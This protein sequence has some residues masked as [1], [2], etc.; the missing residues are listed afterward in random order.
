MVRP[1]IVLRA[2]TKGTM[3]RRA[4]A[5]ALTLGPGLVACSA[6]PTTS[7]GPADGSHD[8]Q[9]AL[10]ADGGAIT[11]GGGGDAGEGGRG[12]DAHDARIPSDATEAATPIVMLGAYTDQGNDD[13]G[14]FPALEGAIGRGLAI[15]NQREVWDTDFAQA[16]EAADIAAGVVPMISWT[17]ERP[18]GACATLKDVTAGVYDAQL[19]KEAKIVV[20][21]SVTIFIRFYKEFTDSQ[22]DACAYGTAHPAGDPTVNGPLF[23]GAWKHVVDVFRAN[24][25]SNVQWIWGPTANLFTGKGGGPDSKTWKYFYPG[26]GYVD[27]IA[28]DNYNK[29]QAIVDYASDPDIANWYSEVAATGK[30]LMQAET[31]AGY[32][33]SLSPDPQTAWV[34]SAYTSLPTKYPAIRAWVYWNAQGKQDYRLQGAGLAAFKTMAADSYFQAT[35]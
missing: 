14:A 24:G 2:A 10:D 7:P 32:D 22:I 23:V 3:Q 35:F 4:L 27:W 28:N 31:G 30:P 11:D 13:P 33:A 1:R 8:G 21:M 20:G 25:V 6:A 17:L 18:H 26:D 12:G 5:A 9:V 15:E 34:K 29:S 16:D 19:A